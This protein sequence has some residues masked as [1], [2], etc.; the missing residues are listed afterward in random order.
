MRRA[1]GIGLVLLGG[2]LILGLPG[3][4]RDTAACREARTQD[5]PDAEQVCARSG[6][7]GGSASS[8]GPVSSWW[9]TIS[10]RAGFGSTASAASAGG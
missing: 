10:Q 6:S 8:R 3:C 5:R 4:E 2:G 7:R 9:H 1:T